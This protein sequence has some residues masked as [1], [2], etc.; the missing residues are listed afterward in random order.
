LLTYVGLS[1]RAGHPAEQLYLLHG[2]L[3]DVKCS[4]FFC[5]YLDVNNYVDPIVPSLALPTDEDIDPTSNEVRAANAVARELDISNP[6]VQLPEI[7]LRSLP[8]CPKCKGL[9]RPGVVWF[10]ESLPNQ[11]L[12]SVDSFVQNSEDVDLILV[13]GTSARVYPAAGYVDVAREKGARVCVINLAEDLPASEMGP[14]DWF[15]QGDAAVLLPE[16]LRPVIGDLGDAE[17]ERL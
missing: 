12:D 5:N 3:F 13:I 15:F 4:S 6:E 2:S 11:V 8:H 9:L 16:L 1:P 14:D 7:D 17:A 10:G